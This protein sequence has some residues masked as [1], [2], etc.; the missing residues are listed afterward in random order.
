MNIPDE[1]FNRVFVGIFDSALKYGG[2]N[3]LNKV[4]E[5]IG[6]ISMPEPL[7]DNPKT[8]EGGE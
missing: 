7:K 8:K 5:A 4:N 6:I 2:M 3:M 1:V